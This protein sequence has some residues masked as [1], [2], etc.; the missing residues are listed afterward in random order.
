MFFLIMTFFCLLIK[1][2]NIQCTILLF[3]SALIFL[4]ISLPFFAIDN[5]CTSTD[6]RFHT[7]HYYY[8]C[9]KQPIA[10]YKN[11]YWRN[12]FVLTQ[13]FFLFR[14]IFLQPAECLL[15]FTLGWNY[16]QINSLSF[17]M[18]ENIFI[19]PSFFLFTTSF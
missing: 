7:I 18:T 13:L 1:V 11:H 19:L 10:L 9:F 8:C 2:F 3:F 15:Q 17:W 14:R 4:F 6:G 12:V 5:Y 16:L